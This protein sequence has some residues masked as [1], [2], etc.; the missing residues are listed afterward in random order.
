MND[1]VVSCLPRDLPEFIEVDLSEL[2]GNQTVRASDL[3]LPTGV[4][5]VTKGGE[6]PAL[7]TVTVT[8]KGG[9][10]EEGAEAAAQ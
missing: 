8:V 2:K 10:A 7:V 3:K 1:V 9:A 5:V 4:T 6:D